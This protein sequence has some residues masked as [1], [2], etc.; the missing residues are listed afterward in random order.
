M[1]CTHN[2]KTFQGKAPAHDNHRPLLYHDNE[3]LRYNYQTIDIIAH[4]YCNH[5]Y[6]NG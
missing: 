5:A 1:T 6:S 2:K 4:H 3:S